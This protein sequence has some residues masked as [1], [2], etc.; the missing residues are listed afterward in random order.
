MKLVCF[1]NNTAGGLVC[2]LLNRK[3]SD[4]F[5]YKTSNLEHS[6]FK[7]GD[8]STIQTQI[9]LSIWQARI[10]CYKNQ[11]KWFGTHAHP[12]CIPDLSLFDDVISITTVTRKSKLYRWLRYYH[13]WFKNAH[14]DWYESQALEKIDKVRELAKNV[15]EAFLPHDN[16]K[17][18]EFEDIVEGKFVKDFN[19]DV[20][21]FSTWKNNNSWLYDFKDNDWTVQ[22]FYEAE[23]EIAT[24]IPFKYI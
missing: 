24:S 23:C 18:I 19:L 9:D 15:F 6:V 20:E 22:R 1:S 5:G 17:N 13:G 21:Y 3:T 12:S 10:E 2:D 4:F 8:T 7:I 14:P 16:C 11:P